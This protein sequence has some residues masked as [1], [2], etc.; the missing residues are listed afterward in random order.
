MSASAKVGGHFV[1]EVANTHLTGFEGGTH[2]VHLSLD[3]FNGTVGCT[4][5]GYKA[6]TAATTVESVTVIANYAGCTTTGTATNVPVA[7]NGCTYTLTVAPGGESTEHTAHLLC[8]AGKSVVISHPNC[9]ATVHAQTIEPTVATP[10]TITFTRT[11]NAQTGKH[12]IT[13]D[14]HITSK[15]TRHGLCQIAGTN[16]HGTLQGSVTVRGFNGVGGPQVSITAT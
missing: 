4:T 6:T 5:D 11:I 13:M 12:E 15:I 16:G 2:N 1:S 3:G 14:L 7:M 10:Q 9:T 8:P